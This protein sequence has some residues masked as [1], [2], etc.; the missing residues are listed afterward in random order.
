MAND[1]KPAAEKKAK[2]KSGGVGKKSRT[3]YMVVALLMLGEGAAIFFVAKI[4]FAPSPLEAVA[5]DPLPEDRTTSDGVDV[6]QVAQTAEVDIADCRPSN[7][8][9]GKLLTFRLRVSALVRGDEAEHVK[10]LVAANSARI[11]DRVNFVI[12]SA[13]PHHLNEP[14]LETIKRRMK[15]ELDQILG[16]EQLILEILIPELLQA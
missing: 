16:D 3:P 5:A 11:E 8:V 13:E 2:G 12:R 14:G 7:K 15:R 1:E 4:M 9:T 10:E 6:S